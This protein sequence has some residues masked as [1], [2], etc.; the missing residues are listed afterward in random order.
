[1]SVWKFMFDFTKKLPNV[2]DVL[3]WYSILGPESDSSNTHWTIYTHIYMYVSCISIGLNNIGIPAKGPQKRGNWIFNTRIRFHKLKFAS[4]IY[5]LI[6]TST[7]PN[8]YIRASTHICVWFD[9]CSIQCSHKRMLR[10]H[11]IVKSHHY[12]YHHQ[13]QRQQSF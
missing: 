6:H 11:H 7:N 8:T 13:W 10:A 2:F 12:L 3:K 1:M 9:V 4:L 5:T